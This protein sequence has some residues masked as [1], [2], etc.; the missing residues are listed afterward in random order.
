MHLNSQKLL[1]RHSELIMSIWGLSLHFKNGQREEK[2]H[3]DKAEKLKAQLGIVLCR[4][5]QHNFHWD[6]KE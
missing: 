1:P 2:N 4:H 3:S 5:K 6:K